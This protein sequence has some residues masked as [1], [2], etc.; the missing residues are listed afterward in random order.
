QELTHVAAAA[1]LAG[2]A[3]ADLIHAQDV[4]RRCGRGVH[5]ARHVAP[6]LVGLRLAHTDGGLAVIDRET[7]IV[8]DAQAAAV[9]DAATGKHT[10][11]RTFVIE[12]EVQLRIRD[13]V[14]VAT[15]FIG[16]APVIAAH[17]YGRAGATQHVEQAHL[18]DAD[19][20]HPRL[21]G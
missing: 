9:F 6:D 13:A 2:P 11:R 1:R 19:T 16:D 7:V 18:L 10:D 14:V 12:A 15:F 4:T 17:G 21:T 20:V 3:L 8:A 5:A